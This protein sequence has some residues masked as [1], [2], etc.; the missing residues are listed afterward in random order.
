MGASWD[1]CSPEQCPIAMSKVEVY[2]RSKAHL[3]GPAVAWVW[4]ERQFR[5]SPLSIPFALEQE[6]YDS[7]Q[8]FGNRMTVE[9]QFEMTGRTED[10]PSRMVAL[11]GR[12]KS[13]RK[14]E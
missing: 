12:A 4:L 3:H 5:A 2:E 14:V 8:E 9:S 10:L 1:G 13:Q 7:P 6:D 11:V